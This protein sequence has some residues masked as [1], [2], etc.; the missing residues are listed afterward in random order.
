MAHVKLREFAVNQWMESFLDRI[1]LLNSATFNSNNVDDDLLVVSHCVKFSEINIVS[2]WT[3]PA[4]WLCCY[5][6]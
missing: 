4:D 5:V 1:S 3:H 2:E 6:I